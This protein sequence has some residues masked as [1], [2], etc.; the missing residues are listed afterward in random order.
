MC[1]KRSASPNKRSEQK[2]KIPKKGEREKA[3]TKGSSPAQPAKAS[4][5]ANPGTIIEEEVMISDVAGA[6]PQTKKSKHKRGKRKAKKK[7]RIATHIMSKRATS[8]DDVVAQL[9]I[10]LHARDHTILS[11]AKLMQFIS[12]H[13]ADVEKMVSKMPEDPLPDYHHFADVPRC[14]FREFLEGYA[15][16]IAQKEKIAAIPA[17]SDDSS[18]YGAKFKQWIKKLTE[19]TNI[20]DV[21]SAVHEFDNAVGDPFEDL[22]KLWQ[23]ARAA[24]DPM[25]EDVSG[26]LDTITEAHGRECGRG[27]NTL[28]KNPCAHVVKALHLIA[29]FREQNPS[30]KFPDARPNRCVGNPWV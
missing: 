7:I 16:V 28:K 17:S 26:E 5:V 6:M 23:H 3:G 12:N 21:G 2:G 14:T 15:R 1:R 22:A 27:V 20:E 8:L 13:R 9:G 10:A 30:V 18:T 19:I 25:V 4:P 24:T 11:V 29:R